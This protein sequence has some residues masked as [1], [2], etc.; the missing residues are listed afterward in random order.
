MSQSPCPPPHEDARC[1]GSSPRPRGPT[2][3]AQTLNWEAVLGGPQLEVTFSEWAK[4]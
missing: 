3:R 4:L 1:R 2:S